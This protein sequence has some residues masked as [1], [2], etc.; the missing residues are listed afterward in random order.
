V[1]AVVGIVF[2]QATHLQ[3]LVHRLFLALSVVVVQQVMVVVVLAQ[4]QQVVAQR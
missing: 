1:V 2:L 3:R 4:P